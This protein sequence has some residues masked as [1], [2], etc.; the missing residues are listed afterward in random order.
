MLKFAFSASF[1]QFHSQD[2]TYLIMLRFIQNWN[3]FQYVRLCGWHFVAY[4]IEK[5]VFLCT[6]TAKLPP[7]WLTANHVRHVTPIPPSW[8]CKGPKRKGVSKR[9]QASRWE[10][11]EKSR[12]MGFYFRP[13]VLELSYPCQRFLFSSSSGSKSKFSLNHHY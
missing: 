11:G 1:H 3:N 9:C 2:L 10:V 7:W 13:I 4:W 6:H 12:W 8:N 5:F